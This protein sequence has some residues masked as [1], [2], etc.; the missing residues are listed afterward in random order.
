MTIR[1]RAR[2]LSCDPQ[3]IGSDACA[4]QILGAFASRA[5]RRPAT[6]D[7]AARLTA[8]HH[9]G[10]AAGD[11]FE[12]ALQTGLAAVLLSPS[13]LF[14]VEL[15]T[16]PTSTEAHPLNDHEL[17]ARLSYFLWSS[18]PDDRLREIADRGALKDAAVLE[19]EAERMLADP[20]ARALA[21][22]FASQW[23]TTRGLLQAT[24]DKEVFPGFDEELKAAMSCETT[25]FFDSLVVRDRPISDLVEGD[26]TY[27]NARLAAHYGI[28]DAPDAGFSEVSLAG[29][30]RRGVLGHASILTVT[31][32]PTR[33]SPAKRGKFVLDQLLCLPPPPPPPDV[34]GLPPEAVEEEGASLREVF[35]RH[36]ADPACAACHESIDPF[37][38]ALERFDGV[39][40]IRERDNGALIDDSALYFYDTPF[41]GEVELSHLLADDPLVARCIVEKTMSYALGRGIG[42]GDACTIDD[43]TALFTQRGGSTRDL[44]VLI[45]TSDAFRARRGEG[46]AP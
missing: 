5:W 10:T 16:D 44:F 18:M 30:E 14:R 11:T 15:D 45:A 24:P 29:I 1:R 33:T 9:A 3:A 37:G 8:L 46:A 43:V 7:E 4:H 21:E 35:E 12:E 36:R 27:V 25:T 39:G 32:Y 20:K 26:T 28:A 6:R 40:A 23:L 13:F 41:H 2:L 17:A 42:A 38:F 31:S 22:N 34:E 19:A